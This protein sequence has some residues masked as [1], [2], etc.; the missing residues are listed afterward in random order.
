VT[1]VA[2]AGRVVLVTG[3]SRGIG[4]SVV[5]ALAEGGAEVHV[6]SREPSSVRDLVEGTGGRTWAADLADEDAVW[7]RLDALQDHLGRAPDALVQAAGAFGLAPLAETS[8]QDFDRQIAVNLR[9][10]FVVLRVLLPGFLERDRGHIVTLGSVAGRRAFPANGAYSASKYGLRGLHEVL[11]EELRGT[12]VAATLLEPSA[13]D[14]PLWDPVDPDADPGLPSRAAML[15]P[16]DVARAVVFVLTRPA[17]VRI[18]LL[19]IERG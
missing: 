10:A 17:H 12:G 2:L 9:G 6:L 5:A 14:T 1:D 8:V 18:P 7:S 16:D 19:Q 4:R 13:T 15:G 3:G 11:I